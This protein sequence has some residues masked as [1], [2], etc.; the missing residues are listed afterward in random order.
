MKKI[1][2]LI[3]CSVFMLYVLCSCSEETF[4]IQKKVAV[5]TRYT[6]A[7]DNVQTDTR[8]EYNWMTGEFVLLPDTHSV[9]HNEKYEVR[10]NITYSNGSIESEWR[11]VDKETYEQINDELPP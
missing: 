5:D 3:L 4:D 8:Y 11:E 10:Y 2:A 6:P 9:H 1:F 7:Y